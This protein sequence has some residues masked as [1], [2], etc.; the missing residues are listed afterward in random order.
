MSNFLNHLV[1]TVLEFQR[2]FQEHMLLIETLHDEIHQVNI[3]TNSDQSV[4]QHQEMND[5]LQLHQ[6]I[7][8]NEIHHTNHMDHMNHM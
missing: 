5:H 1:E 4:I 7:Q 2:Q 8:H 3:L 6:T